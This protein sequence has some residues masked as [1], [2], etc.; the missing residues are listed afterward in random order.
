MKVKAHQLKEGDV[1]WSWISDQWLTVEKVYFIDGQI[2]IAS[3]E[4][5]AIIGFPPEMDIEIQPITVRV[6]E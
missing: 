5:S 4:T 2:K 3:N 6:V 1:V